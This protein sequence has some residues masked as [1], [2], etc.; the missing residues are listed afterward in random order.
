MLVSKGGVVVCVHDGFDLERS[1]R[2][3]FVRDNEVDS[4]VGA[5]YFAHLPFDLNQFTQF[6]DKTSFQHFVRQFLSKRGMCTHPHPLG[7][8]VFIFGL[9]YQ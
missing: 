4:H 8:D 6:L 1:S 7:V 2:S 9:G 5:T 3:V